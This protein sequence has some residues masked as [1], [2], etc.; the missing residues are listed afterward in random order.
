[1]AYLCQWNFLIVWHFL[2]AFVLI[3]LLHVAFVIVFVYF[4]KERKKGRCCIFIFCIASCKT[5]SVH[6]CSLAPTCSFYVPSSAY[7]CTRHYTIERVL[8]TCSVVDQQYWLQLTVLVVTYRY[9]PLAT[10]ACLVFNKYYLY[11][12]SCVC[13]LLFSSSSE[14]PPT[15]YN[16]TWRQI[17]DLIT[18]V[19]NPW[20]GKETWP[21]TGRR[22]IR[23]MK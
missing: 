6:R 15:E 22:F 19:W 7:R 14:R 21:R 23:I 12:Y 9:D 20:F 17:A 4:L 2:H 11:K 13:H 8:A 10:G 18:G 16:L 1:M 3:V 5:R